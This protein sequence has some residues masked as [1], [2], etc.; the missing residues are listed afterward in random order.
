M[1]EFSRPRLYEY[2]LI[3]YRSNIFLYL[4]LILKIFVSVT[5]LLFLPKIL[6]LTATLKTNQVSKI[7]TFLH[8]L[9][10]LMCVYFCTTNTLVYFIASND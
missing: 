8:L 5:R 9:L 4:K 7:R 2:F 10:Y 1:D 6:H 3:F